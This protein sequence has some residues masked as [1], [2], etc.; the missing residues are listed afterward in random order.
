MNPAQ[1]LA[2]TSA[3]ARML[4]QVSIGDEWKRRVSVGLVAICSIT[5]LELLYSAQSL[6]DRV[7]LV[8]L[9]RASY[10]WVPMPD[11]VYDR[12]EE[13]QEKLTV[14]G[15]H[16][17]AG[18]V[19]LLLAATAELSGLTLLHHDHNFDQIATV[20]GQPVQWLTA[21]ATANG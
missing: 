16:R 5:E 17:S 8:E 6:A 12:A 1:Y 19:D 13:V 18:P 15:A 9:F 7:R 20:T 4:T 11:R 14:R 2:D 21:S 10:G 3:L